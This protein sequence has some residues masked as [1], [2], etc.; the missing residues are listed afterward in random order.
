MG[1]FDNIDVPPEACKCPQCG[2]ELTDWQSKDGPC[3]LTL[4]PFYA[5]D[6][7]YTSCDSCNMWVDYNYTRPENRTMDDYS[8]D[9]I[10]KGGGDEQL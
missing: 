1:M 6:N 5:V 4:L 9:L 10:T 8:L 3:T 7:F 2:A